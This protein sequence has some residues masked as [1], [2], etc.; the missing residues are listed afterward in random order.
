MAI[1][2]TIKIESIGSIVKPDFAQIWR[3]NSTLLN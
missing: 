3:S 1:D 2:I